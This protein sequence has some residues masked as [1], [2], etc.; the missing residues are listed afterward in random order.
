MPGRGEKTKSDTPDITLA[1]RVT[2]RSRKNEVVQVRQDGTVK[3]RLT[4]P[5]VEGK[6]NQALIQFLAEVLGLSPARVRIVS[7]T[8]GRN[9]LVAVEGMDRETAL[10]LIS[11]HKVL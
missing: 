3:V 6:A 10:K 9:K 1:V 4:A 5:P 11:R 8:T 7:G 2:P